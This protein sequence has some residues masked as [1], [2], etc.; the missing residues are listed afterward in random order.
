MLPKKLVLFIGMI[1]Y[2]ILAGCGA[3]GL[4]PGLMG[5]AQIP[6]TP[7]PDFTA[8]KTTSCPGY[9]TVIKAFYDANDAG[10]YAISLSLLD[11]DASVFTWGEG[12][13][14]RHWDETHLNGF[15][16]IRTVFGNR[17]FRRTSGQPDAPVYHE[18]DF[19]FV[20]NRAV[21]YMRPDRLGRDGKP[22]N[23]YM[24]TVVFKDCKIQTLYVIERFTSP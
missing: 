18:T 9:L 3:A 21:Y 13:N 7:T 23:P 10:Q 12:V 24:V 2:V 5:A 4:I 1:S 6:A 14:G 20:N 19:K 11:P 16:Q 8:G 22:H 15:D 17:G